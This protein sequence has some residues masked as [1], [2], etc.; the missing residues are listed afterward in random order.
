MPEIK[1]EFLDLDF[2]ISILGDTPYGIRRIARL[3][4]GSFEGPKL[5]GVVLPGGAAHGRLRAAMTCWIS[6]CG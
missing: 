2:E 1:T 4:T 5:K 3:N 6:K